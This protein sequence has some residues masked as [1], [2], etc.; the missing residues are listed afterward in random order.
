[1]LATGWKRFRSSTFSDYL[2]A[3]AIMLAG[4]ISIWLVNAF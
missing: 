4:L 2:V 1:M 3:G